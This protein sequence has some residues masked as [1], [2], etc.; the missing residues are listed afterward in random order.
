MKDTNKILEKE[1]TLGTPEPKE[2]ER[3]QHKPKK[4]ER[5]QPDGEIPSYYWSEPERASLHCTC[6][7]VHLF[8]CTHIP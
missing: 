1:S 6:V 4:V 8:A 2:V 7:Y 5:Q 3:Q